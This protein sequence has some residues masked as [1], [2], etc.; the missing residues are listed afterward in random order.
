MKSSTHVVAGLL[1]LSLALNGTTVIAGKGGGGGGGGGTGMEVISGNGGGSGIGGNGGGGTV[2]ETG[3]GG[4][5]S[6]QGQLYGDLYVIARYMGGETK[7]VP[8]FDENG[9]PVM[10]QVAGDSLV[11][12]ITPCQ[13]LQQK[14][15]TATAVGGEPKL[16]EIFATYQVLDDYGTPIL[17]PVTGTEYYAAPYPS[18]CVQPVADSVRWGDISTKTGLNENRLPLDYIYDA[19]HSATDCAV[20]DTVFLAAGEVWNSV[21]YYTAI[22]YPQLI[23]EVSFGRLSLARSPEAIMDMAF[24]EAISNLNNAEKIVLDATGRLVLTT[25]VYDEFLTNSDGTPLE[26]ATSPVTKTIDSPRENLA[27]YIK[28]MKDGNLITPANERAPVDMSIS[29]GNPNV[30]EDGPSTALRPTINIELMKDMGLGNLVDASN[31][32]IYYAKYDKTLAT[33]LVS[34]TPSEG[35]E[36]AYGTKERAPSDVCLG[37]DLPFSATF[38]ASAAD[39]SGS[40]T[41]D[42]IVYLNSILRINKVVGLSDDGSIDYSKNPVYFNFATNPYDYK[43]GNTFRNRGHVI[44]EPGG[45]HQATY[46]GSVNVLVEGVTGTWVDTSMPIF[47]SVFDSVD[48]SGTDISGFTTMADDDVRTIGYIH[49]Y[50]IPGLR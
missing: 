19:T 29:G 49:T 23:Q 6:E 45:G 39:K 12:G 42:Q 5:S 3:G 21:T 35:Y 8:E 38:F 30:L 48:Y 47:E 17:N 7:N 41:M 33:V 46:D 15:T 11:C 28:L 36:Q 32:T 26:L 25:R 22:S 4:E 18:Q 1:F 34:D 9:A 14:W 27:I 31:K 13:V 44:V 37:D 16:S 2:S 10:E 24:D 40:I 50:Q 20:T 43:R